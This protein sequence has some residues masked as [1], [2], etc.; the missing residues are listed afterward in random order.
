MVTSLALMGTKGW[1][2]LLTGGKKKTHRYALGGVNI[3]F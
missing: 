3:H 2:M 1:L